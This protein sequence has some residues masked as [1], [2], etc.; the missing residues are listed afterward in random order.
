MSQIPELKATISAQ[1]G[2][3][4]TLNNTVNDYDLL[5]NKPSIESVVLV[6]DKRLQDLGITKLSNS[7]IETITGG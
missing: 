4:G 1:Q 2:L 6:G 3:S 7:D 5:K